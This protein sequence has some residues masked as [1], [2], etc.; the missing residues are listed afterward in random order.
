MPSNKFIF[1]GKGESDFL[2]TKQT[3]K[4]RA[5]NFEPE[6]QKEVAKKKHGEK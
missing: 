4:G 1:Q 6:D 5:G 3:S 2:E